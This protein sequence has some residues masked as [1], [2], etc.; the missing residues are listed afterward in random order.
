MAERGVPGLL[1]APHLPECRIESFDSLREQWEA[2]GLDVS[3]L[4]VFND[5]RRGVVWCAPGCPVLGALDRDVGVTRE[6]HLRGVGDEAQVNV[7]VV[8][9][10]LPD[11][12]V[13][14]PVP[15]DRLRTRVRGERR[16]KRN[17]QRNR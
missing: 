13:A 6:R 10:V 3:Q 12:L 4:A 9:P 2:E 14:N 1:S 16:N 17:N 7:V 15:F 8:T 5:E 11:Q